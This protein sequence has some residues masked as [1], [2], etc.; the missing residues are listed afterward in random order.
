MRF[1]CFLFTW[2]MIVLYSML[3]TSCMYIF[4]ILNVWKTTQLQGFIQNTWFLCSVSFLLFFILDLTTGVVFS[5]CC[6]HLFCCFQQLCVKY[7]SFPTWVNWMLFLL[8]CLGIQWSFI[9]NNL[10]SQNYSRSA[11]GSSSLDRLYSRKIRK[12]LVHHKQVNV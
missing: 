3:L 8:C 2:S 5:S 7:P 11:K 10:Q 6:W 4:W 12:Q 1:N 9:N